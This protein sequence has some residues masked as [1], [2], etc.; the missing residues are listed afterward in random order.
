MVVSSFVIVLAK[1]GT[2]NSK[3]TRGNIIETFMKITYCM[4]GVK[5]ILCI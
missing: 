4:I 3:I 2:K 5:N 1:S